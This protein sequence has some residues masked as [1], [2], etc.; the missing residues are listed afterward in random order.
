LIFYFST[1]QYLRENKHDSSISLQQLNSRLLRRHEEVIQ[2][3]R[4]IPIS[5][6]QWKYV[7]GESVREFWDI[8]IGFQ[9]G[10]IGVLVGDYEPVVLNINLLE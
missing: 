8:W 1:K 2:T 10:F 4:W 7:D 6:K 5:A 3:K 9:K